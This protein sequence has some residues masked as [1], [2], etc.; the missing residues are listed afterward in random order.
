MFFVIVA[1]RATMVILYV[2]VGRV[3]ML[4]GFTVVET[5]FKELFCL[6]RLALCTFTSST[7]A[8]TKLPKGKKA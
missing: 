3:I 4:Y 8:H 5:F 1:N 6:E 2:G 7:K